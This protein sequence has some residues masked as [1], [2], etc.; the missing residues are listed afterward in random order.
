MLVI[1]GLLVNK[2]A[3]QGSLMLEGETNISHL[4]KTVRSWNI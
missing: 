4:R 3:Y 1:Y 2:H